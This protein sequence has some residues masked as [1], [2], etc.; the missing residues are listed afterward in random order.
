VDPVNG[1]TIPFVDV[2]RARPVPP[3]ADPYESLG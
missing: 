2:G 1:G 3:P